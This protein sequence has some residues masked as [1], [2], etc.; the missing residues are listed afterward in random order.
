MRIAP[1][2]AALAGYARPRRAFER[3]FDGS[4]G[5][6]TGTE[7]DLHKST[8]LRAFTA[9]SSDVPLPSKE[10]LDVEEDRRK[11]RAAVQGNPTLLPIPATPRRRSVTSKRQRHADGEV[12]SWPV[13]SICEVRVES[14][15]DAH[16]HVCENVNRRL[17]VSVGNVRATLESHRQ[18]RPHRER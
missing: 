12:Y 4:S 13:F 6:P 8:E 7:A 14:V 2:V 15:A 16:P 9:A 18:V 5:M 1:C 3:R 11:R 17:S 10:W